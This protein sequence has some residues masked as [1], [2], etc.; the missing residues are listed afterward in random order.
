MK[1][2]NL[3]ASSLVLLGGSLL[4]L[5]FCHPS[6]AAE[7]GGDKAAETSSREALPE[8]PLAPTEAEANSELFRI[9]AGVPGPGAHEAPGTLTDP[10]FKVTEFELEYVAVRDELRGKL[11]EPSQ[12]LSTAIELGVTE[13]GY[14]NPAE[15][16]KETIH[17]DNL[18]GAKSF[19]ASAINAISR[20]LVTALGKKGINGVLVAPDP[21]QIDPEDNR[22]RRSKRVGKLRLLVY[23]GEVNEVRTITK[24]P[25]YQPENPV[26]FPRYE[27]ISKR[28]PLQASDL[29]SQ[30][31]LQVY[32]SRLNRFPGRQVFVSVSPTGQPSRLN[33]DYLVYEDKKWFT[34]AQ[35]SNN[36]TKQSGE[37]RGRIGGSVRQLANLDDIL[38]AEYSTSD[39]GKSN[40]YNLSYELAP[41]FPDVFSLR[42]YGAYS[43][44]TADQVGFAN[45]QFKGTNSTL[46]LALRYTPIIWD[47]YF[48]SGLLGAEWRSVKIDNQPAGLAAT[49][50]FLVPYLGVAL[51][52]QTEWYNTAVTAR[53]EVSAPE[54][55]GTDQNVLQDLG[56]F[57]TSKE[58]T[59]FRWDAGHS[60]YLEPLLNRMAWLEA[61]DWKKA[62]L[63]HEF[64]FSTHGQHTFGNKRLVPQYED[65]VGGG[66]SVRGYPES[67]AAGDSTAVGTMEYRVHLPRL[68]R[69]S[70]VATSGDAAGGTAE[71]SLTGSAAANDV[72]P[73]FATRPPTIRSR[74]DWDWILKTFIDAGV[75]KN[76]QILN[77]EA[78]RS[79]VGAGV[80]TEVQVSK[81]FNVRCDVGMALKS[82]TENI[83]TPVEN[84]SIRV[85]V[86]ATIVW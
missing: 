69:P 57:D 25:L 5:A 28:S 61:K 23:L 72:R 74:P 85:T 44:F 14:R 47:G 84:G 2:R 39:F 33:L 27:K 4:T 10:V 75:T 58:F 26:N 51:E 59:I 1:P 21:K 16:Q 65:V 64:A 38:S 54:A 79:L 11:P 70:S 83:V 29:L 52:K 42:F 46:G 19:S 60:F 43:E 48:V 73:R 82:V 7:S 62:R 86:A 18:G 56:R 41:V 78:N 20:G 24:G 3:K 53:L 49:A 13:A 6:K 30:P 76:N 31:L 63:A 77:Q 66:N 35:V 40:A 12:L 71:G 80:G 50:D 67:V 15:G 8:K 17:L 55:A 45:L 37:L 22:D 34:Y 68:L 81:H 9:G 36:G 32:L